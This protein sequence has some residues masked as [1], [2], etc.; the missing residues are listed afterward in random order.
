MM[1]RNITM[2]EYVLIMILVIIVLTV[3]FGLLGGCAPVDENGNP[4]RIVDQM[5]PVPTPTE[6]VVEP[7]HYYDVGNDVSCYFVVAPSGV[8]ISC[9]SH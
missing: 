9:V 7:R 1:S 3:T 2:L 8:A 5:T 4:I 6:L